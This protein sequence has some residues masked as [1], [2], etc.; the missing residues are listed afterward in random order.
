MTLPGWMIE[1]A[2]AKAGTGR[3]I[4]PLRLHVGLLIAIRMA[5]A[6]GKADVALVFKA[7]LIA[8]LEGAFV[9]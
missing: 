6:A 8:V 7:E 1:I 2:F 9:C 4:I 3:R 5:T